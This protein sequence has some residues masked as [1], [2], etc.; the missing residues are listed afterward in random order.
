MSDRRLDAIWPCEEDLYS[1][2]ALAILAALDI[3]LTLTML[4]LA[5]AHP[6][7]GDCV[8]PNYQPPFLPSDKAADS[9]VSIAKELHLVL[10]QYRKAIIEERWAER[11]ICEDSDECPF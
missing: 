8:G 1:D 9:I 10:D 6:L 4:S 3:T 7:L 11:Y 2:P 5:A